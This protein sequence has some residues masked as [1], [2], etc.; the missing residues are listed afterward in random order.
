[1]RNETFSP[2]SYQEWKVKAEE[3][4]KGKKLDSLMKNTY[5]NIVLKPLYSS[6][7]L[8]ESIGLPGESDYRR[9]IHALGYHSNPWK[10]AQNIT[11]HSVEDLKNILA[12]ALN[13]GQTALAFKVNKDLVESLDMLRDSLT[14]APLA[15]TTEGL[16]KSLLSQL[17]ATF[18]QNDISGFIAEDP[19]SS[20]I[21]QGNLPFSLSTYFDSWVDTIKLSGQ[22]LP[23]LKTIFIDSTPYHNGGANAVQELAVALATGVYYLQE[24]ISRGLEVEQIFGK[25]IF[26]FQI[27]SNFF[28]ELSKIR[29]ARVLWD[30]IGEAYGISSEKRGIEIIAETSS[31]TKTL[32]DSHVNILRAGNEAFAAVLGGVQYLQVKAFNDL[33]TITTLSERL[34]R[35]TQLILKEESHLKNIV[36]PA[37]G[38][39]YI[40]TLTND[41]VEKAWEYFLK[42]DEKGSLLKILESNWL[43]SEIAEVLNKRLQDVYTRK[44]S[45]IGTNVYSNIQEEMKLSPTKLGYSLEEG[46]YHQINPILPLRLSEPY[47]NLR[48][49]A[50]LL[51]RKSPIGLICLG[52]L[53]QHKVRADF[54][55][56]L[57]AAGGLGSKRSNPISNTVDAQAFINNSCLKHFV[58]CSSNEVY[59]EMGLEIVKQLKQANPVLSFYL[60]GLPEKD[61]EEAWFDSGIQ[62]FIH[63][64]TNCYE[65][66]SS[67]MTDLEEVGHIE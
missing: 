34:A 44:Q 3:S 18:D 67:I 32:F 49:R 61:T 46:K 51:G 53:K 23:K 62:Q 54:V 20:L 19:I 30:K 36:D 8:K 64:N 40:E 43:Q 42:M 31:F 28:M 4:L 55:A 25:M 37:G 29:A 2:S 35:N 11:Y 7:D 45:I 14:K 22:S 21:S 57:L 33:E 48:Q 39:W 63:V 50:N 58:I 16:Q 5:E 56:G 52:E 6:E 59:S 66:L 1:M 65:F 26:K 38:S 9:G 15:I 10:I 47:E 60:A 41:L 13:K 27:G 12:D 24:L 17:I